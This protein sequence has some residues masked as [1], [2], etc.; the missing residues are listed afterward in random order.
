MKRP[1]Q[2]H[3]KLKLSRIVWDGIVILCSVTLWPEAF[4]YTAM[5]VASNSLHMPGTGTGQG[6]S[7]WQQ[8]LPGQG[9]EGARYHS[10]IVQKSLGDSGC[11]SACP[12]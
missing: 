11:F 4:M 2:E 3:R 5:A 6:I 12:P 10:C 1:G 9:N 7:V 8:S